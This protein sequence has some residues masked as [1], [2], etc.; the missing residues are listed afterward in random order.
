MILLLQALLV[1]RC[2]VYTENVKYYKTA[3]PFS[4]Q[5]KCLIWRLKSEASADSSLICLM[6]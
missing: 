3:N 5:L 1:S 4:C 2:N 6:I